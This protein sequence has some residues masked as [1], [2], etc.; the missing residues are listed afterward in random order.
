MAPMFSTE[1][2]ARLTCMLTEESFIDFNCPYCGDPASFPGESRGYV[3][4]CPGCRADF[5]VPEDGSPEG[6]KIPLPFT[7]PRLSL[8]RFAPADW[9]DLVEVLPDAGEEFV[10]GWLERDA[11]V[12]LMTPEQTF[13]LGI[14]LQET[15]KLIGFFSLNFTDAERLQASLD[16]RFNSKFE[17]PDLTL[18]GLDALVSFCFK[19][20]KLHRVTATSD[21]QDEARCKLLEDLG[22]RREGEFVKNRLVDGEWRSTAC[23]ATLDLEYLAG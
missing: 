22:M 23:Y 20:M 9:Q 12:R 8:R 1:S 6:R 18:E 16:L 13:Y 10:L 2:G 4:E 15:G 7:A 5:I 11:H 21:S 14:E 17:Q 3:R 19:G